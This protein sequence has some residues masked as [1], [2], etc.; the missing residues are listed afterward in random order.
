M[1]LVML[2]T[3]PLLRAG[4]LAVL[5]VFVTVT[6]L[7]FGALRRAESSNQ[8]LVRTEQLLTRIEAVLTRSVDAETGIRG[9]LLT[10]DPR[11]LQPFDEAERVLTP[12][13]NQLATLMADNPRQQQRL[14]LLRTRVGSHINLLLQL[15]LDYE[16]HR[17]PRRE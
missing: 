14:E 6:V 16:H 12:Q 7:A 17:P 8:S 9:F 11:F 15:R 1:S 10:G 2:Q 4:F 5:V 13:L 3:P